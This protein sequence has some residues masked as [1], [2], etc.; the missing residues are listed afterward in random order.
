MHQLS[1]F[2]LFTLVFLAS[3]FSSCMVTITAIIRQ[4]G[5]WKTALSIVVKQMITSILCICLFAVLICIG[6]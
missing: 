5:C 3:T 1:S 4:M 6:L 2:Q